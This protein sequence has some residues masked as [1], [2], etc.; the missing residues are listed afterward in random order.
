MS[1]S[2]LT[3]GR[4]LGVSRPAG[5]GGGAN[6]ADILERVLDKGIVIA[7][8]IQVNLL[9]IELL[10]IRCGCWSRRSSAPR[11]WASTGGSTIRPCRRARGT[12]ICWKRTNACARNSNS[13]GGASGTMSWYCYAVAESAA[14]NAAEGITGLRD[15]PVSVI[16]GA[17]LTALASPVPDEEFDENALQENLENLPWLE[18]IARAH[19]AVVDEASRRAGVLPLRLAT[20][21]RDENRVREMLAEHSAQFSAALQ[22]VRDHA[23]WGSRSSPRSAKQETPPKHLPTDVPICGNAS[24]NARRGT[25]GPAK[26]PASPSGSSGN[27]PDCPRTSTGTATRTPP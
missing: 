14:E 4:P 24:A 27:S 3:A 1:E 2:S 13:R 22:R 20:I 10:T 17:G 18:E 15:R 8:D 23:E 21:Y 19:N 12:K 26:R 16:S 7:G 9:D 5:S 25:S 11:K 6:L